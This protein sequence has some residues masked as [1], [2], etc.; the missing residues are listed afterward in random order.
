MNPDHGC[1]TLTL[2][3][4]HGLVKEHITPHP[5]TL[6]S[7]E[8]SS[9]PKHARCPTRTALSPP[10]P[11][12]SSRRAGRCRGR[13]CRSLPPPSA[14]RSPRGS[15]STASSSL[16]EIDISNWSLGRPSLASSS[17]TIG[18]SCLNFG[19]SSP[20]HPRGASQFHPSPTLTAFLA[21]LGPSPATITGGTGS[22]AGVDRTPSAL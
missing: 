15:E 8:G 22:G 11:A 7:V 19:F 21:D 9:A 2:T 13:P 14:P 4:A 3:G 6:S 12:P 20:F 5:L 17:S 18:F 1:R 10:P 16:S